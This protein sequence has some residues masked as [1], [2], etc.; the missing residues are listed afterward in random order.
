VGVV[1]AGRV[2]LVV[3]TLLIGGAL[4]ATDAAAISCRSSFFGCHTKAQRA[5]FCQ[6]ACTTTRTIC[7]SAFIKRQL[8]QQCAT[9]ALRVCLT[10]GGSCIHGCD[11]QHPCPA[12]QQCVSGR[13]IM[14]EPCKTACGSDCCGGDY[15]NCGPD[16]HCWTKPCANLCGQ[17]CCGGKYPNCGPDGHCW[18]R[19]CATL[20]GNTC[21][22]ADQSCDNGVC[23]AGNGPG[24][25]GGGGGFPTNL[26]PGNYGLVVCVDGAVSLPC[27][28]AGTIPLQ[29]AA[30]F[31]AAVGAALDQW[32]AATAGSGCARG[33]A[34]YSAFDG[35][36]FT[37]TA[38][39]TCGPYT[40]TVRLTLRLL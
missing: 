16:G 13:C 22:G 1:V 10:E 20:C 7:R 19:P 24:G 6:N 23:R 27:Q 26:P 34:T 32:L 21:C 39:A 40:E 12:Q 28:N 18:T 31:Q 35:S 36:S 17:G 25:G 38:S 37:A 15:P 8:K 11:A 2:L 14:A 5:R 29:T 4:V 33:A 30:Q 9:R 3:W